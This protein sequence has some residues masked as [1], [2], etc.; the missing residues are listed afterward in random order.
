MIYMSS[1]IADILTRLKLGKSLFKNQL[2][3]TGITDTPSCNTCTRELGED[4]TENIAH[5]TFH[6]PFVATIV[7]EVTL[8]FFPS[9]KNHFHS[10]HII[11]V[12]ITDKHMLYEGKSGH[13]IASIN[14][15]PPTSLRV[16]PIFNRLDLRFLKPKNFL[17]ITMFSTK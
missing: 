14:Q 9:I 3:K 10:R 4:N 6:C 17:D 12:T 13:Q 1:D 5:A 16:D 15:L 11:L 8:S 2:F 7:K